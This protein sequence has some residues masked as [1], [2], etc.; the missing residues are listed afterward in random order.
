MIICS[1]KFLRIDDDKKDVTD[2]FLCEKYAIV[3]QIYCLQ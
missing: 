3:L 2:I 1:N